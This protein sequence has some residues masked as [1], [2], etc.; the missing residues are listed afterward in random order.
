[1]NFPHITISGDAEGRGL[2]HGRA[3]SEGIGA[4]LEIYLRL[5]ARPQAQV[6]ALADA[7]R[8]RIAEFSY[9]YTIEMDAIA[10]GAGVPSWQISA[11]NS[12][13]EILNHNGIAAQ[14]CTALYFESSGLLGQ[15]WDW[16]GA[17]EPLCVV[18]TIMRPDGH[19]MVTLT[20]PGML[21]KIGMNNH[22]VGVCLNLLRDATGT[23]GVPVHVVLRAILDS[24]SVEQAKHVVEL[25]GNDKASHLLIADA[26]GTYASLELAANAVHELKASDGVAVHTN[27]YLA[28][29][30]PANDS[31]GS[32]THARL[33]RARALVNKLQDHNLDG[34]QRVLDDK[35]GSEQAINCPYHPRADFADMPAGTVASIMMDLRAGEMYIRRGND[36]A[37]GF[38]RILVARSH[39]A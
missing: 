32:S 2:E 24:T 39:A 6:R 11:L 10:R 7:Y 36:P 8:A 30:V 3:L 38:E 9:D 14:E 5:F 37:L 4:S 15:N 18:A 16:L 27:H 22:G 33:T 12:R 21:A 31:P 34:L 29:G 20:E 26:K 19:W 28:P 17:L 13:T 1:M 25:S 23:A 35:R